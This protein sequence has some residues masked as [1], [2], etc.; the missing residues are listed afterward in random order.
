MVLPGY[1]PH[2]EALAL[3]YTMTNFM[4]AV[5]GGVVIAFVS[6]WV[7]CNVLFDVWKKQGKIPPEE[8]GQVLPDVPDDVIVSVAEGRFIGPDEIKDEAFAGQSMGQTIA[9]EPSDGLIASP[10][11]GVI[12]MIFPTAHAFGL[13]MKDGTGLLVHIGIDTVKLNGKG[14][15][16][17]KKQGD[18]VKAGEP[19]V[20]ADLEAIRKAGYSP[21]TIVVI[22]EPVRED[23]LMSF[24]E[25]GKDVSRG[26]ILSK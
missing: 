12:E 4:H 19:V 18:T 25:F 17:M 5:I 2:A 3:G 24:I 8:L 21:Q 22:T 6:S 15:T 14:F 13:R 16:L 23:E 1:I 9:V 26:D 10:A 11:N 20:R 7:I